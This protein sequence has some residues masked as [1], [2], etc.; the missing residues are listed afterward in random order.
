MSI[1][2]LEAAYTKLQTDADL[3]KFFVGRYGKD[4]EHLIGYR[5]SMNA[6]QLPA[7]YYVPVMSVDTGQVGGMILERISV[8]VAVVEQGITNNRFDGVIQTAMAER[9]ILACLKN[10]SLGNGAVYLGQTRTNHD[11]CSSHPF[12][13]IE[14]SML[15]GA[16]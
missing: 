3:T 6:N 5:H 15:L 11:L 2:A 10:G 8:V 13:E 4:A 7:V 16:R 14:I 9:L 1:K 12:Y